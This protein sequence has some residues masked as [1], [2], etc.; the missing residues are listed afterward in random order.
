MKKILFVCLGNICRSP[1]AEA[2][3]NH[4]AKENKLDIKVSSA[5][6]SG[7]HNGEKAH[8]KTIAQLKKHHITTDY[9][10]SKQLKPTDYHTFDFIIAMDQNNLQDI[11]HIFGLKKEDNKI[12]KLLT[13][14]IPDPWYSNNFEE[15]YEL[16]LKGCN[17][18]LKEI[19]T[20]K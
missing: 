20:L 18:L 14:D 7:Y 12:R 19:T 2:I 6:T 3:M 13:I 8:N 17:A 11:Y 15:T 10:I 5:G 1:M 16:C 9:L 4:L